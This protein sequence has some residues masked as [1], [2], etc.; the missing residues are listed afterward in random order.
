MQLSDGRRACC[1][2]HGHCSII[3]GAV[4]VLTPGFCGQSAI[5]TMILASNE[6]R[7]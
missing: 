7:I 3:N 1:F 5:E 6:M 2:D 4:A